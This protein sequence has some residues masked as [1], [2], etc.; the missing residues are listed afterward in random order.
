MKSNFI[1]L[2]LL[3]PLSFFSCSNEEQGEGETL[4]KINAYNLSVGEFQRQLAR[5]LNF[6]ADLKLTGR[7]KE[8]F[9]G[10]LIQ[11]ALLI[12][13]AKRLK[14]D[15][16]EKFIR[17]IE[18]HWKSTLIRDLLVRKGEEISQAILVSQSEIE[19]YY[20]KIKEGGKPVPPLSE[21]QDKIAN[22]LKEK[23]KSEKLAMWVADLKKKA[24]I[25]INQELFLMN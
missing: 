16:K 13:E 18:R 3:L 11:E 20:E 23:K 6:D 1:F 22:E 10:Q 8:A 4:V 7:V 17:T 5:E 14:L 24:T 9:L 15:R 21:M 2:L 19:A 12:Q 25:E